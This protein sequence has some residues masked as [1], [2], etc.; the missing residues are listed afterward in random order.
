MSNLE[1]I[2]AIVIWVAV[3]AILIVAFRLYPRKI[4]TDYKALATDAIRNEYPAFKTKHIFLR[5][6][7]KKA[8]HHK[9]HGIALDFDAKLMCLIRDGVP[10]QIGFGDLIECQLIIEGA[11]EQKHSRQIKFI[12]T[13]IGDKVIE[14]YGRFG[15]P[16][17]KPFKV[18]GMTIKLS[19]K[20]KIKEKKKVPKNVDLKLIV[21]DPEK[22][23][24]TYSLLEQEEPEDDV[25][26]T[27]KNE[28]QIWFE[29]LKKAM[30]KADE[31]KAEPDLKAQCI[32]D[33]ISKL[34]NLTE[35]GIL[36]KEEFLVVKN[37][38]VGAE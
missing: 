31:A 22:P 24:H 36:T 15:E 20:L 6:A 17:E 7:P 11:Q 9:I 25:L 30:V 18:F 34:S 5:H 27:A 28:A 33:E 37:R 35:Q 8:D 21:N 14:A 13:P 19:F 2:E 29:L 4:K 1:I 38:L 23:F 3:C 32:A 26:A 12:G 10:Q 16:K